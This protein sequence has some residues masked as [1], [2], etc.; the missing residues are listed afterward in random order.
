MLENCAKQ[1]LSENFQPRRRDAIRDRDILLSQI[2]LLC[3]GRT[4]FNDIDL[5]RDDEL[6]K[7]AFVIQQDDEPRLIANSKATRT[8][9]F[10]AP[11]VF[12][13]AGDFDD[14][15]AAIKQFE[16]GG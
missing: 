13:S 1:A 6:F 11:F 15:L 10:I 3:N 5:Y 16:N 9:F 7:N 14:F 2:G 12:E 8:A 4:N